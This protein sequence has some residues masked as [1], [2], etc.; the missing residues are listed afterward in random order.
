MALLVAFVAGGYGRASAQV[1]RAPYLQRLTPTSVVVMWQ[2]DLSVGVDSQVHY[3]TSAGALDLAA[4]G[5]ATDSP[6]DPGLRNHAVAIAGLT[7]DTTYYYDAG[8]VSGGVNAGGS[9]SFFFRPSSGFRFEFGSDLRVVFRAQVHL[10][11]SRAIFVSV[12]LE[13]LLALEGLDLLDRHFQLMRDPR[14]GATLSHPPAD[15]V[16]L[17]TQGPAAHRRA[18][19]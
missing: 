8:T 19:A 9:A 12:G 10:L 3:G 7:P 14:V 17:R 2:T 6:T 13:A 18:G 11:D 16:K 15:L 1:L 4:T 5:V